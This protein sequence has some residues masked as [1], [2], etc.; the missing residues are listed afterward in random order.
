[1]AITFSH[2]GP[3]I[4]RLPAPSTHWSSIRDNRS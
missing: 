4:Y 3:T 2:G 1:M